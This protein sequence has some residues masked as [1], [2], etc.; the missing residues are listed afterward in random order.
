MIDSAI[1]VYYAEK[2]VWP[3]SLSQLMPDLGNKV[4][5]DPTGGTYYI[6]IENGHAKAP[7]RWAGQWSM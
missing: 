5:T 4:P 6:V 2:G 1:H 7:V 3:T